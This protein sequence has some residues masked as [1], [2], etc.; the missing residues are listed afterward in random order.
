MDR[1]KRSAG[2][3][4]LWLYKLV[5]RARAR[6]FSLACSGGFAAFGAGSVIQ[7]P[8]RLSGESRIS[9]GSKVFIGSGAFLQVLEHPQG[10]GSIVI[11]DGVSMT[12]DC[13]VSSAASVTFGRKVLI[14][15]NVYIADHRHTFDDPT[16]AILDQGIEQIDPVYIGDGAW[17]GQNVVVGPGVTIGHGA[18]VGANS[19]VLH[20]VPARSVAIG[21]PARVVRELDGSAK[22]VKRP[23][24]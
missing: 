15:R 22:G 11:G 8:V 7:P 14:A 24:S 13:V 2:R 3:S 5:V 12:G 21:A 23:V 6:G 18:V 20:D 16:L 4:S 10:I 9:V 19:V 1:F 17:L